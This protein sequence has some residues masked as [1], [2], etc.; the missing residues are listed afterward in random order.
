MN[1]TWVVAV[2]FLGIAACTS[3]GPG[4]RD[5]GVTTEAPSTA[6][7][8]ANTDGEKAMTAARPASGWADIAD[9]DS[10]YC[11]KEK[12]TGTRIAQV[13]CMTH[14]ERERIRAASQTNV[15]SAKRSAGAVPQRQ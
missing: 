9:E 15:D 5:P 14:T 7:D 11:R 1:K 8:P 2:A 3:S 10:L 12:M 6:G 4:S 13:V